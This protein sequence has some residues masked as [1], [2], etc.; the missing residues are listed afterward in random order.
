MGGVAK[1]R[2]CVVTRESAVFTQEMVMCALVGRDLSG[3]DMMAQ[4]WPRVDGWWPSQSDA[5]NSS[6]ETRPSQCDPARVP[7]SLPRC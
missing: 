4:N 2:T 5:M 7:E 1:A 6:C 3:H